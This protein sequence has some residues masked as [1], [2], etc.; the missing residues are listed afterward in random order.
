MKHLK[1]NISIPLLAVENFMDAQANPG[2][3]TPAQ[4]AAIAQDLI[5]AMR[6]AREKLKEGY[7]DKNL[8]VCIGKL[9]Y[10]DPKDVQKFLRGE[11]PRLTVFRRKKNTRHMGLYYK[12]TPNFYLNNKPAERKPMKVRK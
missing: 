11:I 7:D 9:A 3:Y 5:G 2:K 1:H 6:T 4:A 12:H 8:T 10:A